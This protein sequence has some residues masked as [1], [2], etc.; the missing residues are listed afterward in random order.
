MPGRK[1]VTIDD[2][3]L[4]VQRIDEQ[5]AANNGI[6]AGATTTTL[7][8]GGTGQR[9]LTIE[10]RPPPSGTQL[11]MVDIMSVGPRYFDAV[12]KP[13]VRGRIFETADGTAGHENVIVNQRFISMFFPGEDAMGRRMKLTLQQASA[14]DTLGST[15]VTIVGISPT[16]RQQSFGPNGPTNSADPDPVVYLPHR[17]N[18]QRQ[19]ALIVRTRSDPGSAVPLLRE[20]IREHDTEMALFLVQSMEEVLVQNRWFVRTFGSM[21]AIFASIALS[22]RGRTL[23][24]Y[25]VFRHAANAGDRHSHG[26]W[27]CTK[28]GAVVVR[29]AWTDSTRTGLTIGMGRVWHRRLLRACWFARAPPIRRRC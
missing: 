25:R 27:R 5:L 14:L 15:W 12:G 28:A 13:L 21:F 23:R 24:H 4:F 19:I 8:M 22:G 7:P 26:A 6:V 3:T 1:Y 18:P 10:G 29:R 9:Q 16:I 17:L 11:P 20:E 2:R